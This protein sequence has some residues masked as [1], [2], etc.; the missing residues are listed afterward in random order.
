VLFKVDC[1]GTIFGMW[2]GSSKGDKI[3]SI[4][5]R[6]AHLI[7]AYLECTMHVQHLPRMSNWGAEVTDRLSRK[8]TT[9]VQDRKLVKA[10]K[11]RSIPRRLSEWLENPAEDWQLAFDLLQH[12]KNLV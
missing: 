7:A 2:N 3:A 11:L 5:I 12:V 1:F 10:F 6:A 4:L 8:A 9:T